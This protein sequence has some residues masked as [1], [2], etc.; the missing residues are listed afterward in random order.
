MCSFFLL[1]LLFLP[2][3]GCLSTLGLGRSDV[4][5]DVASVP[6][7]RGLKPD[8]KTEQNTISKEILDLADMIR[9]EQRELLSTI[10][11]QQARLA[12]DK[13]GT[14]G[15][16]FHLDEAAQEAMRLDEPGLN[17]ELLVDD[18]KGIS[19]ELR[20]FKD[21]ERRYKK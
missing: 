9:Q 1:V 10:R 21:T 3:S 20:K 6:H 19:T 5:I 11:R 4:V 13:R 16:I 15:V 12:Q 17:R 8:K 7:E 18:I 2:L 14:E